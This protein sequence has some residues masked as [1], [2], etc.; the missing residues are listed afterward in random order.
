MGNVLWDSSC[1]VLETL[2]I[3]Y[4]HKKTE[5]WRE[6]RPAMN[7]RTHRMTEW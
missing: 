4:K 5:R 1:Y 2:N 6:G 3:I 7:V